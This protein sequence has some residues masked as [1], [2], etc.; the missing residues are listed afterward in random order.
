MKLTRCALIVL[1]STYL[2]AQAAPSTDKPAAPPKAAAAAPK[3]NAHRNPAKMPADTPVITIPGICASPAA[4]TGNCETVVTRAQFDAL[5]EA[6]AAVRPGSVPPEMRGRLALQYGEMLVFAWEAEKRGLE[7]ESAA[8]ALLQ[9]GRTQ[10][11]AQQLLRSLQQEAHPSAQEIQ[12]YFDEHT[13]DYQG[14]A[15]QRVLVPI[16]HAAEDNDAEK[17]SLKALAETI[18]K[19]LAAGED[20]AQLEQEIYKKLGYKK[21]PESAM[22]LR[23]SA[24]EGDQQA[25]AKLKAGEVSQVFSEPGGF[26][27]YKSEGTRTAPLESVKDEIQRVLAQEKFK[28]ATEALVRD[29]KPVLNGA[30]FGEAGRLGKGGNPHD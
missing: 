9:F 27:V 23:V 10:V 8:Q 28:A 24:L 18:R 12:K 7:K 16:G 14:V 4:G 30:Y 20:A 2:A 25:V 26:V 29:R 22:L 13:A 17:E 5:I 6:L 11:L 3:A 19:R 1:F 15:V 21:P